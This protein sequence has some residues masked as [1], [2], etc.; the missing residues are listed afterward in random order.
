[1]ALGTSFSEGLKRPLLIA[2]S[3]ILID[4]NLNKSYFYRQIYKQMGQFQFRLGN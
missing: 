2:L 1:M 3:K 4:I